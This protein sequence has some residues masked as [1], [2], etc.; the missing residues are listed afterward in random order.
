MFSSF[1]KYLDE[2]LPYP[3]TDEEAP[4]SPPTEPP[5]EV[6][7]INPLNTQEN[8]LADE[9]SVQSLVDT[10]GQ[11]YLFPPTAVFTC[12]TDDPKPTLDSQFSSSKLLNKTNKPRVAKKQSVLDKIHQDFNEKRYE[13]LRVKNQKISQLRES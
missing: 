2:P 6:E 10:D 12:M 1:Q 11:Q 8:K 13:W 9:P 4:K 7:N 3:S 5:I